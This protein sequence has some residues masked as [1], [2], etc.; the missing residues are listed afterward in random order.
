M[1]IQHIPRGEAVPGFENFSAHEA[2]EHL[3]LEGGRAR[4]SLWWN[5][6][7]TL[8]SERIG[9]VGHF[10]AEDPEAGLAVLNAATDIL[11]RRGCTVAVGPMNGNT[12]RAYRLVTDC[13]T[14]PPFFMEPENPH[15]WPG[16]FEAAGFAS[17]ANYTSSMVRNLDREDPRFSRTLD[18]LTS[19]G[20]HIRNLENFEEDLRKIYEVSIVGFTRNFLYTPLSEAAF[21]AQYLPYREKILSPF[22]FLAEQDGK[23][24]GYLFAIPDYAEALRGLPIKTLVGKTLAILPGRMF[25]GLGVVLVE[26]LHKRAKAAGFAQVVHALQ[27]ETNQVRNLSDAFGEVIRKY[28][29]FS[30]SLK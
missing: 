10:S 24:V 17:L 28:T 13:G 29:L 16:V 20:I 23:P 11:Q 21:L 5:Q 7:P 8:D 14:E 30:R 6:V 3:V 12:W 27:N 19:H 15:F 1:K 22:V 9:C 4:C 2:D 25:A 18:R 26:M